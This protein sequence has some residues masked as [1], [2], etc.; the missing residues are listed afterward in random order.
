M[1]GH[2]A[3]SSSLH[4]SSST[5]GALLAV[6]FFL[7]SAVPHTSAGPR[8]LRLFPGRKQQ[9]WEGGPCRE[10]GA[11]SVGAGGWAEA[12]CTQQQSQEDSQ[13]VQGQLI[14]HVQGALPVGL[15]PRYLPTQE[16]EQQKYLFDMVSFMCA[17]T[18][19]KLP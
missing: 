7:S 11:L 8:S 19:Q 10:G 6:L 2:S 13:Q 5:C 14:Q 3:L 15:F 12:G 1:A 4:S 9:Q 16:V 17:W 18:C